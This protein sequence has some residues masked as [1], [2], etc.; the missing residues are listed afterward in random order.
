MAPARGSDARAGIPDRVAERAA[1]GR[2]TQ[3]PLSEVR[4][5]APR[6]RKRTSESKGYEQACNSSPL[7]DLTFLIEFAAR[8]AGTSNRQH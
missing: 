1:R 2:F 5:P 4:D 8:D 3:Y 6:P 7:C